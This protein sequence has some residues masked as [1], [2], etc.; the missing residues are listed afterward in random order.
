MEGDEQDR[1]WE[2]NLEEDVTTQNLSSSVSLCIF[3]PAT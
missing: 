2:V 3:T 1:P